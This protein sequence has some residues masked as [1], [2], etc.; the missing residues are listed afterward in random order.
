MKAKVLK[1]KVQ[2]IIDKK[3]VATGSRHFSCEPMERQ[4]AALIEV[5]APMLKNFRKEL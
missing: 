5:L 4:I 2:K 1:A 3:V